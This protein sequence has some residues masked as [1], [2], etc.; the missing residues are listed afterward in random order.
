MLFPLWERE[1]LE[2]ITG[3]HSAIKQA[4]WDL[5]LC[6]R[7]CYPE[8]YRWGIPESS[9]N[10]LRVESH[11]ISQ[12]RQIKG[13]IYRRSRQKNQAISGDPY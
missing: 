2:N 1:L 13:L 3:E 8:V 12:F 4:T 6:D 11:N 10:N 9:S 7:L 5:H